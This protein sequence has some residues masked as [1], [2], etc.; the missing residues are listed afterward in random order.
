MKALRSATALASCL[1]LLGCGVE[2]TVRDSFSQATPAATARA[3]RAD[4]PTPPDL[5]I[6]AGAV[7]SNLEIPVVPVPPVPL[8]RGAVSPPPLPT[9]PPAPAAVVPASADVARSAS[10]PAPSPAD[11]QAK[12][13]TLRQ[14]QQDGARWYAGVDSYIV[15]MTRREQVGGTAKPEEIMMFEFRKEPWSVHF[16]WVGKAGHDR[17]VLYVKGQYDNKIHT[18]LAAGDAP[19]MP[20]GQKMALDVD[21]PLVRSASRHSI[22]EAGIGSCI[23][24][25]GALLDAQEHGDRSHGVLTDLGVQKRPEFSQPVHGAE[26]TIP[27]GSESE[28]PNGG[29]RLFYFD[30]ERHLPMLVITFD[31]RNQEVEYYLYDRLEAPVHLDAD[32]FNPE[33]LWGNP[34]TAKAK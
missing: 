4:S 14:L 33:K 12:P 19:F 30:A 11:S 1:F 10:Q 29:R 24:R 16:K 5:R 28:L 32:D 13:L 20:A 21:S 25:F 26:M 17:E 23:E 22:T 27:P 31:Q 15:R 2:K 8:G 18:R 7:A 3:A 6:P 34:K 9:P